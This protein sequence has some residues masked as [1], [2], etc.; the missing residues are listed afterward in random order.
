VRRR[1]KRSDPAPAIRAVYSELADCLDEN[2]P[3]DG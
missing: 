2:L 1:A 3:W